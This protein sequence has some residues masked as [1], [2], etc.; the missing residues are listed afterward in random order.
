[1]WSRLVGAGAHVALAAAAVGLAGCSVVDLYSQRATVYNVESEQAHDQGVLL[2]IVRAS[3]RR[4]RAYTLVQKITGQG[5]A[6]GGV[7]LNVPFGPRISSSNAAMVNGGAS[8]GPS[9][10]VATLETADFFEGLMQPI[11]AQLVDL[12]IHGEFPRDLL[13]NLFFEK[14]V[15]RRTDSECGLL[16]HQPKCEVV[17]QNY[18]GN[19]QQL[20][21]YQA[22]AAYLVQLGLSTEQIA[23]KENKSKNFNNKKTDGHKDSKS[24]GG[25]KE[26]TEK[27]SP[28][29]MFCFSP[30][31]AETAALVSPDAIC[32]RHEVLPNSANTTLGRISSV[33]SVVISKELGDLFSEIVARARQRGSGYTPGYE[34]IGDFAGRRVAVTLYTRSSETAIYYVGEIVRRQLYPDLD[35]P[36]LVQIKVLAPFS[37]FP[38]QPCSMA[39]APPEDWHCTNVFVLDA[40][41]GPQFKTAFSIDY[42]G[43]QYSIPSGPGAGS[44]YRSRAGASYTVLSILR[45][46]VILNT[47][48]KSLPATSVL[49]ISA[50]P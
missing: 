17:L 32:G 31:A 40:N 12:Y 15:I 18:P 13:F 16:N 10:E 4:P 39:A 50:S 20:E 24:D 7:T 42:E 49:A 44:D 47:N 22:F 34:D 43:V 19:E 25:D 37:R 21:L 27:P 2:N 28:S 30:R 9:F 5:S 48:A 3:L 29:Y 35:F 11:P 14:I 1:V 36:G 38:L 46:L 45:Q 33:I 26:K 23:T 6:T 8:G 41:A